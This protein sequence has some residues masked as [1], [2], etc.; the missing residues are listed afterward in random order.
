MLTR[1]AQTQVTVVGIDSVILNTGASVFFPLAQ[2]QPQ[3]NSAG[4][5]T[6]LWLTTKSTSDQ[7][8]NRVSATVRH[9][10]ARPDTPDHP[11]ELRRNGT[12]REWQQLHRH[13]ARGTRPAGGRHR[14]D[15]AGGH[16][17]PGPLERT[18][19][20]GISL[21]RRGRRAIRRVFNTEA[22]V[23]A[24]AGW[25]LGSLLGYALFLGLVAFVQHDFGITVTKV[26]PVVSVPVALV[27]VVFVT[28]IVVRPT[29]RRAVRIDP[30][31]AL[32]YE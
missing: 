9:G 17:D 18:R 11:E 2:F 4:T 26:F 8:V 31:R 21:P 22:V 5:V 10:S 6:A 13:P 27:A 30:G 19:E 29:L 7:F 24:M 32:R 20:V 1:P 28:L 23:M 3:T 12:E 15:R 25:A 16:A 14:P